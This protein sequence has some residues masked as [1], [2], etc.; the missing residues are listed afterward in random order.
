MKIKKNK[1]EKS[2]Q[3]KKD[4]G[5]DYNEKIYTDWGCEIPGTVLKY[6][7][8]EHGDYFYKEREA[9]DQDRIIDFIIAIMKEFNIKLSDINEQIVFDRIQDETQE[10]TKAISLVARAK[11][12]RDLKSFNIEIDKTTDMFATAALSIITDFGDFTEKIRFEEY[13]QDNAIAEFI[14]FALAKI[15]ALN[16]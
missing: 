6:Q 16:E 4:F 15:G 11:S 8:D 2:V 13:N 9:W 3:V 14:K 7:V 10:T 5:Q 12:N 1:W